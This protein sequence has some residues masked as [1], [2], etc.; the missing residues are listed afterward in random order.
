M[1]AV[2]SVATLLSEYY[3]ENMNVIKIENRLLK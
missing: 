2:K 1:T 3:T